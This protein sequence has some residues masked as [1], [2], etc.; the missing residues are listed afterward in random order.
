MGS[1]PA[2]GT[3]T[4]LVSHVHG[5]KDKSEWINL[6]LAEIIVFR[7]DGK[8]ALPVARIRDEAWPGLVQLMGGTEVGR[9]AN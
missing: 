3:N 8:S 1:I 9:H 7:P 2:V 4:L 6:E 5:S